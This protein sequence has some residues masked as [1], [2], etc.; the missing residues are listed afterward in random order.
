M[1]INN[2]TE[3]EKLMQP[4]WEHRR[5]ELFEQQQAG[6]LDA[7][8]IDEQTGYINSETEAFNKWLAAK[9]E[10]EAKSLPIT[11]AAKSLTQ[12]DYETGKQHKSIHSAPE[13]KLLKSHIP[14]QEGEN[15]PNHPNYE[16][17]YGDTAK[18]SWKQALTNVVGTG[19]LGE[20][21]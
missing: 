3:S 17:I 20:D 5:R 16:S 12:Q 1:D 10:Q 15:D 2:L 4:Y 7:E 13:A 8:A 6:T 19:T 9:Q 21:I 14:Y 11:E 18:W